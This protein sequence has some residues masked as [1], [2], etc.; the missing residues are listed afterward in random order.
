MSEDD[1]ATTVNKI[2]ECVSLFPTQEADVYR[3]LR[4]LSL[5]SGLNGYESSLY[6]LGVS[7]K[8]SVVLTIDEDPIFGQVIFTLFR[9][10]NS[11]D[12][13]RAYKDVAESLYQELLHHQ[14]ETA[15]S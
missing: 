2:N 10:V 8:L 9:S 1:K 3:Q 5:P 7:Q 11:H 6:T 4:R 13:D 15:R 12:L 14:R